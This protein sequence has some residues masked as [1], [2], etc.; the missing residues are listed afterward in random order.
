MSNLAPLALGALLSGCSSSPTGAQPP[1][2]PE[3]E[4]APDFSLEDVNPTSATF[5]MPVSPRDF[6]G[7]VTGWYFG[8]AS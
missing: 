4:L 2:I 7:T 8:H 3:D 6:I 1:P 5:G